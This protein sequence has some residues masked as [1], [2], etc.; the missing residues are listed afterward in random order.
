MF[1]LRQAKATFNLSFNETRVDPGIEDPE[2]TGWGRTGGRGCGATRRRRLTRIIISPT[3]AHC[4]R[5]PILATHQV[6]VDI[7][8]EVRERTAFVAMSEAAPR[9][10]NADIASRVCSSAA[11]MVVP[12]TETLEE[13]I[14]TC[15]CVPDA[16]GG[17]QRPRYHVGRHSTGR[18]FWR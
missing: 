13:T 4:R 8:H 7:H 12:A 11:A 14:G 10:C 1:L 16:H 5:A 2:L 18:S 9:Y 3:R 6:P 15:E 17:A